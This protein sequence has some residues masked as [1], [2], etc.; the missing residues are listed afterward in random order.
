MNFEKNK[1]ITDVLLNNFKTW[2]CTENTADFVP[3][4]YLKKIDKVIFE[5][6]KKQMKAAE[7]YN[8]MHLQDQGYKLGIFQKLQIYFSGLRPLYNTEK[9]LAE[10]IMRQVIEQ[11]NVSQEDLAEQKEENDNEQNRQE[12][13]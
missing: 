4:K 13:S 8:L 12:N 2:Q 5:N 10:E 3:E 7:I 6:V 11:E 1:L 9:R